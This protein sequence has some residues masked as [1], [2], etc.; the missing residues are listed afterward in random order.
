MHDSAKLTNL[1]NKS[2]FPLQI[3]IANLVV[4]SK[5]NHGWNLLFTEHAWKKKDGTGG[6]IDIVLEDRFR[7]SVLVIECKRVLDSSWIF[8]QP[9]E[10]QLKH[11]H[12][13]A[14]VTRYTESN[15]RH[16]DWKDVTLEPTTPES[17]YC[18][19]PGQ[20][21]KA[22]P[23]LERVAAE[24]V[25]A[26]EGLST[27][28]KPLLVRQSDAL[29]MY[30]NVIVTTAS[31]KV[32][33]FNPDAVSIDDGTVEDMEFAEAPY[34]RFRKQ[35]STRKVKWPPAISDAAIVRAK[36]DTVFVVNSSAFLDFLSAFEVDDH[37]LRDLP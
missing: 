20:D 34:V 22:K 9:D 27:E 23:M 33:S 13:K 1:V 19:V 21:A 11:R 25:S 2:G 6:F 28:E 12:A 3:G 7:T 26:T 29:R 16:F 35:L 18:V 17:E 5:G 24:V 10:K 37:S 4:R 15:F 8:L 32:C 36:E 30:F 14:W 31:V